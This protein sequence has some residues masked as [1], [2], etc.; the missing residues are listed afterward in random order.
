MSSST[1]TAD[2]GGSSPPPTRPP[3]STVIPSLVL[4]TAT[5]NHQY[6]ADPSAL[7]CTSIVSSAL[8]S[9]IRAFDTSPYYGPSE[10]L[11]GAA[12]ASPAVRAAHPRASYFLISKAGRIGPSSF[13]YSPRSLRAS[14]ERSIARL[15][16]AGFLD[17]VLCHD[18]EFVSPADL[19]RAVQA[20]RALRD[21]GLVRYVGISGFPVSLLA[22]RAA[23]V[24]RET[25]EPLDAVM[26]YGHFCVQNTALGAAASLAAFEAARVGVLLNASILNMGLLTT[27]GVDAG[28]QASWHPSPVP[29]RAACRELVPLAQKAGFSLED[30][31]IRWAIA[32]WRSRG[33]RFG[34]SF[35]NG[36][37]QGDGKVGIT[38]L[39]VTAVSQLEESIAAFTDAPATE[40]EDG[41]VKTKEIVRLVEEE[42]WP[43]LGE[44]KDFAWASPDEGFVNVPAEIVPS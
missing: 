28:P 7:P 43:T 5:F 30:V 39:G 31:C 25:A 12:L 42:M 21:A 11:L 6:A 13:N 35:V 34:S 40:G 22:E 38:V 9:G 18:C 16:G 4:G 29:L 15:G 24:L 44:W 2:Q 37:T 17:L 32:A 19:L 36:Q 33:S 41:A 3:I 20:L 10:T 1:L 26:S 23:L 8:A 27:R 14:V